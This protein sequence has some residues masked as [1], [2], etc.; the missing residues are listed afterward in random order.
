MTGGPV[1][2]VI[3]SSLDDAEAALQG[4]ADRLELCSALP[5]GGL[6]PSLGLL[7]TLKERLPVPVM[8][9]LRPREGGMAYTEGDVEV[10]TR[11]G[12][13]ALEAGADGL[14]FGFLTP[15]GEVDVPVVRSFLR[16]M[17]RAAPGRQW[18]FHR[19]F[20]VTADPD[21]ALEELVDLGVTR[22]LT[23]GRRARAV[24][25]LDEIRR[26][27][28]LADGRIEIL[29]GG[30]ITADDVP[31]VVVA[32]GAAQV[33]LSLRRPRE[34]RSAAAN[35]EI[36]FG[37]EAPESELEYRA[38]DRELVARAR[39]LLDATVSRRTAPA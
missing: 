7:Q 15:F 24:E 10:M 22:I 36:R 14:V 35:P 28:E 1:L 25:G 29:P 20:D 30:G 37:A 17:S 6:T 5:L 8:F 3:A 31:G 18:V 11:D 38:V 27:V 34:D 12:E 32:T 23:S 19:A 2:E 39:S 4:G 21:R 16:R 26:M 9:M 33:H 13:L